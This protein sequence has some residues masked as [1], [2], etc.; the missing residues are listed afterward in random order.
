MGLFTAGPDGADD[1]TKLMH[2]SAHGMPGT[3]TILAIRETGTIV[4]ENPECEIDLRV[5]IGAGA[6]Y[7]A[8]ARQALAPVAIPHF[9]PGKEVPVKVDRSDPLS[10]VIA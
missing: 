1:R 4:G 6:P 7:D 10:L 3:A 2:L 5:V 9:Q 8:T